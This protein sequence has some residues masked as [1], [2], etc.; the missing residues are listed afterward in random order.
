MILFSIHKKVRVTSNPLAAEP[1]D[2]TM[3]LATSFDNPNHVELP[4]TGKRT[5]T[6]PI[7]TTTYCKR[8]KRNFGA[9]K[10][11]LKNESVF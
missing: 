9:S 6:G 7:D 4:M 1:E 8:D 5:S 3:D 11:L 10:P 2:E